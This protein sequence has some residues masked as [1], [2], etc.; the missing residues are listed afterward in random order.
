[1]RIFVECRK[2]DIW[3]GIA[4]DAPNGPKFCRF[5]MK[6]SYKYSHVLEGLLEQAFTDREIIDIPF[7]DIAWLRKYKSPSTSISKKTGLFASK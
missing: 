4:V 3:E 6:A 2:R 1:M 7:E 5:K